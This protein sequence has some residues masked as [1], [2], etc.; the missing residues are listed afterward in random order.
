VPEVA[1]DPLFLF[2]TP[3]VSDRAQLVLDEVGED[4]PSLGSSF[5]S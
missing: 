4:S 1:F 5:S 2:D 3:I